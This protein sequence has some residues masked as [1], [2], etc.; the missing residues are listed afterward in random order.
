VRQIAKSDP[1]TETVLR[2]DDGTSRFEAGLA[3][4]Q[5]HVKLRTYRERIRRVDEASTWTQVGRASGKTSPG[6]DLYN[7]RRR[8]KNMAIRPAALQVGN[9]CSGGAAQRSRLVAFVPMIS[10]RFFLAARARMRLR[11]TQKKLRAIRF[12]VLCIFTG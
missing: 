7:V 6:R 5:S 4:V 8:G 3:F 12:T 10:H 2:I 9:G 11:Q 1:H